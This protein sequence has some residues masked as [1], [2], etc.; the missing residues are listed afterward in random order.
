MNCL[1]GVNRTE[2]QSVKDYW[3][4]E[5]D[6]LLTMFTVIHKYLYVPLCLVGVFANLAIVIVLLRPAMRRNPFNLFLMAIAICD[7]TLMA[8]YLG[9]KHVGECH[10]WFFSYY[11]L[12]YTKFYAM[13]SVFV[14]ALSLWLTVNMAVLRYLVLFRG[15]SPQSNLPNC[16]SYSSASFAIICAMIIAVIGS[17]PNMLRYRVDGP[18]VLPLPSGFQKECSKGGYS[19]YWYPLID[20]KELKGYS[21]DKP[22]W[23]NCDWE[24]VNY[25]LASIVLK[26]IPCLLLTIFMTLLV[27]ML[28]EARERRSRLCGGATSGN[29]QAE[30]TTTMLTGIVAV[31]LV[32]EAP[33]GLLGLAAGFNPRLQGLSGILGNTFD[34][35]SL[36]N[37]SVN[38][39]LYALMSHV[40]RRE[41][42]LTFGACCPKSTEQD[43]GVVLT[44]ATAFTPE[45][46]RFFRLFDRRSTGFT[47]VP[48]KP[49]LPIS[50]PINEY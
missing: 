7:A 41:F 17:L 10:P 8:T 32:T 3:N 20:V 47:A 31:F 37:S 24:R 30:R 1:D 42:L 14:H 9:Y 21:L 50:T 46:H 33:Q 4:R 27:R 49:D 43:S 34:L 2:I 40:F 16:N 12:L 35:L 38:F 23:W 5:L 22:L 48:T 28:M 6:T 44:K 19:T 18:E 26:L 39:V 11:W 29:S 25:W 15:Q 36:I 13:V 45:R